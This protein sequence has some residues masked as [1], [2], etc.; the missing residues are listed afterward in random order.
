MKLRYLFIILSLLLLVGCMGVERSEI[1]SVDEV[2]GDADETSGVDEP[3]EE[4]ESEPSEGVVDDSAEV[5]ADVGPTGEQE[6][7]ADVEF[8]SQVKVHA[9]QVT[10]SGFEPATLTIGLGDTV[11]WK[12]VRDGRIR[13]AMV[14]GARFPCKEIKSGVIDSGDT[15]SFVFEEKGSCTVVDSITTTQASEIVIE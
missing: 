7:A 8:D 6:V 14:T 2:T 1:V 10:N 3:S 9:V 11:E 4:I 5:Q 13:D 12:N 15:Y